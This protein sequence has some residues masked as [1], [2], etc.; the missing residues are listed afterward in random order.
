M[1]RQSHSLTGSSLKKIAVITMLI[2][3]I[4]ACVFE[5][6]LLL[7]DKIRNDAA[8][9]EMLRNTDRILRLIGRVSFPI[10][11]FLLVEGFLHTHDRKKYALRL[12]L[13]ALISEIPFDLAIRGRFFDPAYQNIFFTLL[14]GL[15]AMMLCDYF[16]Q[17]KKHAAQLYSLLGALLLAHFFHTDYS[18]RGVLLIE[19]FYLF[20]YNRV[21]Q[22]IAGA[23]AFCWEITAPFAFIPIWFYNGERGK[24]GKWFFYWFYPVHLLILWGIKTLLLPML[25][26]L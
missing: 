1:S 12:F 8:L 7:V 17:K 9:F 11:C 26:S 25:F 6:G 23:V 4:G 13:F 21:N 14:I 19:L 24:S 16:G 18:Y 22:V 15:L 20:R 5:R 3:H 2:D 10:F